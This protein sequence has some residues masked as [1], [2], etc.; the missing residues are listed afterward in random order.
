MLMEKLQA[1][2]RRKNRGFTLVELIVVITI[3][4]ILAA[5]LVPV[6]SK[7]IEQATEATGNANARAVYAAGAALGAKAIANG[8]PRT[9]NATNADRVDYLGSNFAGIATVT[10]D[11]NGSV[12]T[13]TWKATT[14][15]DTEHIYTYPKKSK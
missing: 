12:N 4:A 6:I 9:N 5:L 13:A 3:I 2:R 8:T 14:D 1:A 11:S 10:Y 15:A 7:Y